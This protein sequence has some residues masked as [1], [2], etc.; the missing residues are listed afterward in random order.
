MTLQEQ[1]ELVEDPIFRKKIA[2]A[3]NNRSRELII[4]GGSPVLVKKFASHVV[5]N[6]GGAWL[7]SAVYQV[8]A[9]P[10]I[11]ESSTDADIQFTVNSAFNDLAESYYANI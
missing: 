2:M 11:N 4:A 6:I 8:I 9:N 10:V 1:A 3:M 7:N 5:N